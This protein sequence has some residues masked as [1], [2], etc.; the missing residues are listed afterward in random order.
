M[1]TQCHR[2][3]KNFSLDELKFIRGKDIYVCGD[4]AEEKFTQC[5]ICHEYFSDR[6]LIY[7]D[8][9]KS[10]CVWCISKKYVLCPHCG[11]FLSEYK[12]IN[13]HG[14]FM[15]ADCQK[16]YFEKCGICGKMVEA[17]DLEEVQRN[18]GYDNVC[19]E[20]LND[21]YIRCEDCEERISKTVAHEHNGKFYCTVCYKEAFVKCPSCG[22]MVLYDDTEMIT[23]QGKDLDV[24]PDCIDKY[25]E[26]AECGNA[27]P[28]EQLYDLDCDSYCKLCLQKIVA[29]MDAVERRQALL[30]L[31]AVAVG[32]FAGAKLADW[33]SG[34][35]ASSEYSF[36]SIISDH[37]AF[38]SDTEDA[39]GDDYVGDGL[40]GFDAE[41][42]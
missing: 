41:E 42:E 28:N 37:D 40:D 2:C 1:R 17:D 19:Q 26:C 16:E 10:V 14:H 32:L 29:Q 35:S 34:S 11:S 20:C 22:K 3:H 33:L 36:D 13:F 5:D 25:E 21:Q 12:A 8:D 31:G 4:C 38:V 18:N 27:F 39:I 6:D 15:C 9:N 30:N 23:V 7:T 24:C